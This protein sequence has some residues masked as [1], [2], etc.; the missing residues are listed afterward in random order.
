VSELRDRAESI[1]VR[2]SVAKVNGM[3]REDRDAL[4]VDL[5]CQ[6]ASDQVKAAMARRGR[7]EEEAMRSRELLVWLQEAPKVRTAMVMAEYD[8]APALGLRAAIER[9]SR[10]AKVA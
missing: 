1:L 9:A 8:L 7:I 3:L 4:F 10:E 6:L 5:V 2:L